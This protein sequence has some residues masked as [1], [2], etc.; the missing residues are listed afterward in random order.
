MKEESKEKEP[1]VEPNILATYKKEEL[2]EIIKAQGSIA[3]SP[4][5]PD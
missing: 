2:E 3:Q 4:V 1:Y 5:Q